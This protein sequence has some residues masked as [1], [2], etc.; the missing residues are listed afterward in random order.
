MHI[1]NEE[2]FLFLP[3][4]LEQA[5][6]GRTCSPFWRM[7]SKKNGV[8]KLEVLEIAFRI[9]DWDKYSQSYTAPKV[10]VEFQ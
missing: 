4:Q 2:V 3:R 8:E 7:I 9:I 10:I 1:V 5:R 6:N